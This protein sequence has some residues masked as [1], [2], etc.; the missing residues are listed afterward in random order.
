MYE[1]DLTTAQSYRMN[2][3]KSIQREIELER[4]KRAALSKKYNKGCVVIDTIQNGLVISM[5]GFGAASLG[6][7]LTAVGIPIAL[8]MDVGAIAAGILTIA[9]S[10]I[11]KYLKT[12]MNKHE[13]IRNLAEIKL[14]NISDHISKAI[15]DGIISKEEYSL[16]LTE[17]NNYNTM[18]EQIRLKTKNALEEQ[19]NMPD[20]K[21]N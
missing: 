7:I 10:R 13:K 9:N 5:I 6:T 19:K 8:A 17:Y 15:E 2:M 20:T 14:Y 3:I 1:V 4:A 16:I 21:T 18:K 11:G 12:K